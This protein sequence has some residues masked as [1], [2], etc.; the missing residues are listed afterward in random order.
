MESIKWECVIS[1]GAQGFHFDNG[2]WNAN[3]T[4]ETVFSPAEGSEPNWFHRFMHRLAF[5]FVWR[6]K[7]E[8]KPRPENYMVVGPL[9]PP[10]MLDLTQ[11]THT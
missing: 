7:P 5:G 11:T 1:R 9:A 2:E 4:G 6:K 10:N 3:V 8:P